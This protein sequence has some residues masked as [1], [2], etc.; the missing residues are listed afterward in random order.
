MWDSRVPFDQF[1]TFRTGQRVWQPFVDGEVGLS[2]RFR[3]DDDEAVALY[4]GEIYNSRQVGNA[5]E[6]H[7]SRRS[8]CFARCQLDLARDTLTG[9]M[10]SWDPGS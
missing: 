3:S 4:N 8:E 10:V 5:W 2:H 1:E 7:E 9:L 6:C